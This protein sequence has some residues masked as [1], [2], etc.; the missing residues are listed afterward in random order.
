MSQAQHMCAPNA[1]CNCLLRIWGV[2]GSLQLLA[3]A[4]RKREKKEDGYA[5]LPLI[6]DKYVEEEAAFWKWREMKI[7]DEFV[8]HYI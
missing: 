8:F 1:W 7:G 4:L 6:K 2:E 5:V 3:L